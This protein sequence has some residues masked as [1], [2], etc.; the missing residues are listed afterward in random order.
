MHVTQ[1]KIWRLNFTYH[2]Y[3]SNK[4]FGKFFHNCLQFCIDK[5]IEQ[6]CNSLVKEKKKRKEYSILIII[7]KKWLVIDNNIIFNDNSNYSLRKWTRN[8]LHFQWIVFC[9]FK[10]GH[11]F[12]LTLIL[13]TTTTVKLM[14]HANL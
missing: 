1:Q 3:I 11:C 14:L 12:S 13:P 10:F 5:N 9:K 4:L 2:T 7:I 6:T 8:S